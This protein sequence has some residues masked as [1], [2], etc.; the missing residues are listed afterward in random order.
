MK[1]QIGFGF[2]FCNSFNRARIPRLRAEMRMK[3][4]RSSTRR[5][6]WMTARWTPRKEIKLMSRINMLMKEK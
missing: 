6:P 2:R 4:T 3:R 1:V 5:Q